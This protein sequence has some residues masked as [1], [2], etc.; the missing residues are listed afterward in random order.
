MLRLIHSQTVSGALLVDD[1]DDGL[2]N[3]TA[4]RLGST[5]DP[6]AYVR[7]G[8]ANKPKQPCYIPRVKAANPVIAGYIDL[9]ET[10]R[11]LLSADRGKIKGMQTA[12]LITV[13][14]HTHA[15]IVTP[16]VTSATLDAPAA[17][18]VTI[19]GTGFLSVLPEITSVHL[20][21][22]GVGDVTLTQAQIV[23]VSPGAVTNTSIIID[24]T[25]IAGLTVGDTIQVFADALSSNIFTIV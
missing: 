6:K 23:A 5:A 18:D 15:D 11:V 1:I 24:S 14:S 2:P 19:G 13:V 22:A 9:E 7:D 3:K 10:D 21:G 16:S 12:G 25:L 4:H 20:A 17:G 8:Y